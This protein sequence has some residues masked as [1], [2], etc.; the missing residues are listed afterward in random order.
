LVRRFSKDNTTIYVK[1]N[2][3]DAYKNAWIAYANQINELS[4]VAP[5]SDFVV[6]DGVLTGYTGNGGKVIIPSDIGIVL[7]QILHL[8]AI[9]L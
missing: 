9:K 2:S 6:K 3:I 7:L 1:K 8:Q 4:D 5:A